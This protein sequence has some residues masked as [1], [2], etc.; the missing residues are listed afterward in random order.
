[1]SIN[2]E[3]HQRFI[4]AM[5]DDFNTPEALA[6]MFDCVREMNRIA[7]D[8]PKRASELSATV[9]ALGA[10]LGIFTQSPKDFLHRGTPE[11]EVV[12][13]DNLISARQKAREEKNWTEADKIRDELVALNVVVEDHVDGTTWR[14]NT[15]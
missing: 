14:K 8:D 5:D 4:D 2:E 10:V 13:I 11:D 7:K 1:V 6:V 12:K 3:Y 15:I 9:K